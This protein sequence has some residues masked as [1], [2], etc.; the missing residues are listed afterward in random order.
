MFIATFN[1]FKLDFIRLD[2]QN[3]VGIKIPRV[4]SIKL[5]LQHEHSFNCTYVHPDTKE[6]YC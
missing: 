3:L 5:L 6:K 4:K 1:W 2:L